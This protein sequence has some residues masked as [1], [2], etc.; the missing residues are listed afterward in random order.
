LVP[1]LRT[2]TRVERRQALIDAGW[3]CTSRRAFGH[4]T[5][6]DVCAE[7]EVSKKAFYG[8]FATKQDLLLA[9]LE[10]DVAALNRQL[11]LIADTCDSEVEWVRRFTRVIL[12]RSEDRARVRVCADLW[13]DLLASILLAL[14]D[15][16]M[17]HA[18]LDPAAFP[19]RQVRPCG[20]DPFRP[21]RSRTFPVSDSA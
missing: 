1:K 17:L 13:A 20:R 2:E 3:R 5:V 6:D 15:G 9:L 12:S 14:A 18:A 10:D 4:L 19:L 7:A 21:H 16:L 11:E 8:Y